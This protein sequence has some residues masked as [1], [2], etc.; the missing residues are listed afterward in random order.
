[1]AR[2]RVGS[3]GMQA[4]FCTYTKRTA[5]AYLYASFFDDY[6]FNPPSNWLEHEHQQRQ[7]N[8]QYGLP[9]DDGEEEDEDA[10]LQPCASVVIH[11]GKLGSMVKIMEDHRKI[12]DAKKSRIDKEIPLIMKYESLGSAMIFSMC[13]E[14]KKTGFTVTTLDEDIRSDAQF[15]SA[16]TQVQIIINSKQFVS[17]W[18]GL[19][20]DQSLTMRISFEPSTP[21]SEGQLCLS[22]NNDHAETE[23]IIPADDALMEK[24]SCEK[25]VSHSYMVSQVSQIKQPLMLSLKTSL[26]VDAN[27][28]LS[29]QFMMPSS[30]LATPLPNASHYFVEHQFGAVQLR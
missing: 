11:I 4:P 23:V 13:D 28:T 18:D 21:D 16:E 17:Y 20:M 27:G 22:S 1:M 24:F 10:T 5:H 6:A 9:N 19:S 2:T 12:A 26:R 7:R 14:T 25:R 3:Q 29:V 15:I 30:L 8:S